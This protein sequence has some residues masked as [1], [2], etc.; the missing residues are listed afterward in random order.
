MVGKFELDEIYIS[1]SNKICSS[2]SYEMLSL[3]MISRYS[4]T[5]RSLASVCLRFERPILVQEYLPWRRLYSSG[6][7]S[8]AK[9]V[10]VHLPSQRHIVEA[11]SLDKKKPFPKAVS[12]KIKR[13]LHWTDQKVCSTASLPLTIDQCLSFVMSII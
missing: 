5:V 2:V 10:I 1:H 9:P 8:C 4:V 3:R 11:S 7:P 13:K 12:L 6:V